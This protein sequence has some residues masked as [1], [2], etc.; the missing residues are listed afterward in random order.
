[1]SSGESSRV[2]RGDLISAAGIYTVG[3]FA[4]KGAM[5]LLLPVYAR[6]FVVDDYGR[7][8]L[9]LGL[10][11]LLSVTFEVGWSRAV[12]RMLYE[13]SHDEGRGRGYLLTTFAQQL[14]LIATGVAMFLLFGRG[15]L[16]RVTAGKLVHEGFAVPL[17]LAAA[18]EAM[19][20][21]VCA[22]YRARQSPVPFI[23]FKI[24]Q[25]VAQALGVLAGV[26]FFAD[27]VGAAAI[28]FGVGSFCVALVAV[29]CFVTY[30]LGGRRANVSFARSFASNARFSVPL[31]FQDYASWLRNAA[32][33]YIIAHFLP[34]YSVSI[35]HVG[36]QFG[37]VISLFLYSIDLALA[38]FLYQMM[39]ED[40]A[41]R[42]KYLDISRA[43]VGATFAVTVSAA[44]FSREVLA[45]AFPPSMA[46][47]A[48]IA[49]LVAT[50][51]FFHG[52]Y[53]I[54]IKSFAFAARTTW[55]PVLTL[56]PTLVGIAL[57]I[58]VTPIYGVMGPAVVT[59]FS[60]ALLAIVVY[61]AAQ[62]VQR[63][64]YPVVLHG[65]FGSFAVATG[66]FALELWDAPLWTALVV[67]TGVWVVLMGLTWRAFVRGRERRIF[68]MI[69]IDVAD[70]VGAESAWRLGVE[71]RGNP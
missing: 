67:K 53:S 9:F 16:E 35:Y 40:R 45:V 66:A 38:P 19:L 32:D 55:I 64:D 30:V 25:V 42:T 49:P 17:S 43:M 21:F 4:Q 71:D 51:Y 36:Y 14:V 28:G 70:D 23:S 12:P 52:L 46:E 31:V 65:V 56:G 39:K 41:F 59:L 5:F 54:Y 63:F 2:R 50:A 20:L 29:G 69:T 15:A 48:K 57:T 37:L 34:L 27:T 24:A 62:R 58:L 33:P 1:M 18:A 47:A 61:P 7:W 68:Q 11:T 6:L 3:T 22:S 60:L 8:S 13:Y 10:A 44:L 26:F